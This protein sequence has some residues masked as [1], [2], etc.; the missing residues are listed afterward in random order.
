M[1]DLAVV[2]VIALAA[3]VGWRRG[4]IAPVLAVTMS[5]VGLYAVFA[6]P[7]QGLVPTGAAGIGLGVVVVGVVSSLILR[8]GSVLVGLVHR[9]R[10]LKAADNVLGVPLGIA[11]GLVTV[12]LA[13][14]AVVSFD[15][16][17]GPLHGKASVDQAAV[18]AMRAAVAAN[19]QFSVMIDEGT[20]DTIAA[21]VA[22]SAIPTDQLAKVDQTLGY[23]ESSVRPQ[24]LSSAIAPTLLSLGERIPFI[25][26]HIDFPTK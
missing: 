9:V 2:V 20:L 1:L 23:Y 10:I 24:L 18:A 19:P 4:F 14:V 7:G 21:Q 22:T 15:S 26:R 11:T 3:F 12:Y 5:L 25:G 6:G 13:L 16:V 8:I 17:I